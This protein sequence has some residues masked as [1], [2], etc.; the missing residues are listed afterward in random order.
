MDFFGFVQTGCKKTFL[1]VCSAKVCLVVCC[2]ISK[3]HMKFTHTVVWHPHFEKC[4]S[5]WTQSEVR[6]QAGLCFHQGNLL[7][8]L[9]SLVLAD[10]KGISCER[11]NG[12]GC[13]FVINIYSAYFCLLCLV[14]S[15]KCHDGHAD[16]GKISSPLF[17]SWHQI[18][19]V[20]EESLGIVLKSLL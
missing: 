5:D 6:F 20:V 4:I 9:K 19:D 8:C 10:D 13:I 17:P 3:N 16:R 11:E 18:S 2:L 12:L 1:F 7:L 15:Q 14:R